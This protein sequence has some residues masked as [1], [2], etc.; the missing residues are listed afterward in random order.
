M[1]RNP[2]LRRSV[3]LDPDSVTRDVS[4][5]DVQDEK[6][7]QNL[8]KSISAEDKTKYKEVRSS[9]SLLKHCLRVF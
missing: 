6:S 7:R 9:E 3:S 5:R 8:Q 2:R 1:S 4:T